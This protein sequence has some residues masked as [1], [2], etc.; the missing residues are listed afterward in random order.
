[1]SRLTKSFRCFGRTGRPLFGL[2]LFG[3][4]LALSA[5]A[6]TTLDDLGLRS[7]GSDRQETDAA[8]AEPTFTNSIGQKFVLIPAGTFMMGSPPDDPE[9]DDDERRHRVTISR[10]FYLQTTEVTQGQW[11]EMM[12]SNPSYFKNCGDDC[13][14]EMMSWPD[15]QEFIQRLNAKEGTDKYRLPTEAEWEYACRAGTETPFYFGRCLSADQANYDGRYPLSGC[16]P[17]IYRDKTVP[18]GSFPPNAWGLHDMHGNVWEWC[19]DGYG[20][21]PSGPSTDPQGP[22]LSPFR[23]VRGG[24]WDSCARF[25]RSAFRDGL[26]PGPRYRRLGFR[27]ARTK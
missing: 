13:P 19:Q 4:A 26:D 8:P 3:L 17:G 22:S 7:P 27:L 6:C 2:I 5:S 23:V 14:V 9:R 1:M 11:Q 16:P 20:G 12:G 21:Y 10:P 15:V 24:G 18:V 25:C